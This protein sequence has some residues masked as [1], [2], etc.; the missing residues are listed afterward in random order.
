[1]AQRNL[2]DV[3]LSSVREV[4]GYS[5]SSSIFCFDLEVD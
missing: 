2:R 4:K 1:V 5:P 3:K